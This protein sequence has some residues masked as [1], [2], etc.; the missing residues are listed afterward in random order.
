MIWEGRADDRTSQLSLGHREG[1]SEPALSPESTC[2]LHQEPSETP[3]KFSCRLAPSQER[4]PE[5]A[6]HFV[7]G[8]TEARSV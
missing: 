2:L 5:E 4:K 7:G 6:A 3:G 1:H 8:E